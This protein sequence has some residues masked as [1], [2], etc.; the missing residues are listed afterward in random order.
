MD[1]LEFLRK[2]RGKPEALLS[3]LYAIQEKD[4]Y[5]SEENISSLAEL[6]NLPKVEV[7]SVA[8]FYSLFT[9]KKTGKYII[10]ICVSLP[11]YLNG[12]KEILEVLK[13]ELG[14]EADQTTSDK[15][16]SLE[17]VSCLGLCDKAPAM[18]V[19]E[20]IYGNLNPEKVREIVQEY[21]RK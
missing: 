3:C 5:L 9:L 2:Y 6:L 18:M 11:C 16:F 19:N 12:S 1:K 7:Y 14:I 20:K 4:G 8:S 17:T 10:R 15:K 21:K 13:E